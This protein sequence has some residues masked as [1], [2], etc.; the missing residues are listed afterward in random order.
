MISGKFSKV[1]LCVG[2]VL[3]RKTSTE[4]S[5]YEITRPAYMGNI[6]QNIYMVHSE[7]KSWLDASNVCRTN[8]FTMQFNMWEAVNTYIKI[9]A[10][11]KGWNASEDVW[12]GLIKHP[13]S[14]LWYQSRKF[15]CVEA[16]ISLPGQLFHE[17]Q[18]AVLNMSSDTKS[19]ILYAD[20]CEGNAFGFACLGH[21]GT[22]PDGKLNILCIMPIVI[23]KV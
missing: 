6:W 12:L 4:V 13:N 19:N 23:M 9:K 7:R 20:H 22:V 8:G 5:S 14:S 11:R 15:H 10:E 17:R 21:Y 18:C 2:I 3:Y 16:N 1:I